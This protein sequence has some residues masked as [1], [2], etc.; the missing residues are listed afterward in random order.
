MK[1]AAY[2]KT[3]QRAME[4]YT[5]LYTTQATEIDTKFRT[6]CMSEVSTSRNH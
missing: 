2:Y 3:L 5:G 1:K 6:W 4:L